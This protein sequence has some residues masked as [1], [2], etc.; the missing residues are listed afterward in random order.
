M[1]ATIEES[2]RAHW[3][4]LRIPGEAPERLELLLT[5]GVAGKH[6]KVLFHAFRPGDSEPLLIVKIPREREARSWVI[7][8]WE[9]LKELGEAVPDLAGSAFPRAIFLETRGA[10][11][12]AAQ[13]LLPGVPADRLF[14][15]FGAGEVAYRRIAG[16]ASKWLGTLWSRTGFLEGHERALWEPFRDAAARFPEIFRIEDSALGPV[17]SILEEVTARGEGSALYAYGHG[18]LIPSNLLVDGEDVG[19]VDWEFGARRSL[20]W[21]D[22]VHFAVSFS[23]HAGVL[24]RLPRVE[25]FTAGFLD[26]GWLRRRNLEFLDTSFDEGGVPRDLL[27][28]ALPAYCLYFSVQ[29]SR[30]FGADYPVTREWAEVAL[31]C[32]NPAFRDKLRRTP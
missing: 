9:F 1:I 2:V 13:S 15:T 22:P 26:D 23:L 30:F 18:D 32:A 3:N 20:P 16:F 8:E 19:A 4:A 21:V 28:L 5:S 12:A 6:G 24:R 31:R 17:E 27:P 11:L 10:R 14:A 29:M 25:A 7:R